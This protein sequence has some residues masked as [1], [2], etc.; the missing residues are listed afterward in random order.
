M[1]R[2]MISSKILKGIKLLKL[3]RQVFGKHQLKLMIDM[4]LA[5]ISLNL[6]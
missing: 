2:L 5:L 1:L 4:A 6:L 3:T